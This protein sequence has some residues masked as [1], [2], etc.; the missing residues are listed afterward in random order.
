MAW[1]LR[2][3]IPNFTALGWVVGSGSWPED[4][5][6]SEGP[7]GHLL[8]VAFARNL[9]ETEMLT[10]PV[11]WRLSPDGHLIK[12][13]SAGNYQK[14]FMLLSPQ[15]GAKLG[16]MPPMSIA[17]QRYLWSSGSN[18]GLGWQSSFSPGAAVLRQVCGKETA[19]LLLFLHCH[20]F[21]A[22]QLMLKKCFT[23]YK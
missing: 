21:K 2:R 3:S 14:L 15:M 10:A 4:V 7:T 17:T 18:Q 12:S 23:I 8:Q 19:A 1:R 6:L 22:L 16:E 9:L 20:S 13:S 5:G 11:G